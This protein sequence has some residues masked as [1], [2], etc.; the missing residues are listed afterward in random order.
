M[1]YDETDFKWRKLEGPSKRLSDELM[2]C[3]S[4]H[5]TMF[6]VHTVQVDTYYNVEFQKSFIIPTVVILDAF[7]ILMGIIGFFLDRK[8]L[9]RIAEDDF[10]YDES[11][12]II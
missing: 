4:S 3:C 2:E 12:S 5:M 1:Y 8:K 11:N 9:I 7:L 10:S 6:A